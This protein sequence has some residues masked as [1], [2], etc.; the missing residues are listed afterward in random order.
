MITVYDRSTAFGKVMYITDLHFIHRN[1][2]PEIES[3]HATIRFLDIV[4]FMKL[5][6]IIFNVDNEGIYDIFYTVEADN[7]LWLKFWST[8]MIE[9]VIVLEDPIMNER[10]DLHDILNLN[11]VINLIDKYD[12][13]RYMMR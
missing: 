5:N 3:V 4:S 8:N 9:L 10:L 12:I 6:E 11:E 1:Y 13:E 7:Y 2:H